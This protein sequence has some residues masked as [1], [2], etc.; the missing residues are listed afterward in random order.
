MTLKLF[1]IFFV[2]QYPSS[3]IFF[4]YT[5]NILLVSGMLEIIIFTFE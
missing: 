1:S 2:D 4:M 5:T 3:M